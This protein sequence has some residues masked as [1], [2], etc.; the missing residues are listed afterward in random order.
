M[1]V[2]TTQLRSTAEPAS[3]AETAWQLVAGYIRLTNEESRKGLSAAAQRDNI[4][5]YARIAGMKSVTFYEEPRAI[6]GHISFEKREAGRRLLEDMEGG[7]VK[8]LI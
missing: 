8:V 2:A 3:I 1:T 4:Q 5:Q 6:G 7:R